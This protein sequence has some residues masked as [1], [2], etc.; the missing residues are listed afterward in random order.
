[1]TP[2]A[3]SQT[4]GL[5]LRMRSTIPTSPQGFGLSTLAAALRF[6]VRGVG[7]RVRRML[8][9]RAWR[10]RERPSTHLARLVGTG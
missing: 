3:L 1:M 9:F 6:R 2:S 10:R 7:G 4:P 8:A 5:T